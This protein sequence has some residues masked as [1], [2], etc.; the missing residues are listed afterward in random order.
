ME[1]T[2]DAPACVPDETWMRILCHMIIERLPVETIPEVW[3]SVRETWEWHARPRIATK[4]QPT[5]IGRGVPVGVPVE[6]PA[7]KI[8]E[9]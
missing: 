6:A 9:E 4:A 5:V 2:G 1:S 3:E 8:D 7:L